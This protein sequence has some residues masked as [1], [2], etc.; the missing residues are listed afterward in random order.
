M[1]DDEF[2]E[3]Q[4]K[5]E[6]INKEAKRKFIQSGD[7]V[8]IEDFIPTGSLGLDIALRGG[9]P[10]GRVCLLW[11]PKSSTKSTVA[12]TTVAE[13]QKKG[14]VCLYI[15][16]EG[17]FTR[18]WAQQHGVDTEK[19][20][21]VQSSTLEYILE[22]TKELF[23]QQ[24]ID[25]VVL[26]SVSMMFSEKY[27]QEDSNQIGQQARATKHLINRL[28][29]WSPKTLFLIISQVTTFLGS[30]YSEMKPTGGVYLE[31]I[32]SVS[33]HF[34]VTKSD[35][36]KGTFRVG[37]TVRAALTGRRVQWHVNKSKI[38][39]PGLKGEYLWTQEG[40]ISRESEIA[41]QG[42]EYGLIEKKGAWFV[43]NENKYHGQD[44][45]EDALTD[46]SELAAAL[47][48]E[49]LRTAGIKRD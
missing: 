18:E 42:V 21:V 36:V 28:R 20:L 23:I 47:E 16:A 32:P 8:F 33:V 34:N 39:Y 11:G 5:I 49:I 46:D 9:W 44:S 48:D 29:D 43:L 30:N 4:K 22:Y 38:W 6:E 17:S 14:K 24:L 19:L 37:D 45:L 3:I 31:H 27:F 41:A 40:G 12:L 25:V 7:S 1:T 26:D 35:L 10:T 2:K 15:D 13:A